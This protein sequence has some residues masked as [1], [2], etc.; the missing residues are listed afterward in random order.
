M[1]RSAAYAAR[2]AAKSL[3]AA[4]LAK[5]VLVQ[6]SYAIG[7]SQPLSMFVDSYGTGGMYR[8]RELCEIVRRNF[9]FRPGCIQRDLDLKKPQFQELAA[10]GHMGREDIDLMPKWEDVK[11]LK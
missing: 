9:D 10:Y 11:V 5:R 1:D 2:W 7:V 8:D 3:V 6:V 4:G